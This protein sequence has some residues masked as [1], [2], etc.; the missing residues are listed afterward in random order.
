MAKYLVVAIAETW[1]PN[2]Y[3]IVAYDFEQCR[4]LHIPS[5]KL[6]D[7]KTNEIY[8]DLFGITHCSIRPWRYNMQVPATPPKFD[9]H[10][11]SKDVEMLFR[12]KH[13]PYKVFYERKYSWGFIKLSSIKNIEIQNENKKV[14]SYITLSE[15]GRDWRVLVKDFR[16]L[17]YWSSIRDEDRP[18]KLRY[19][20]RY[21]NDKTKQFY[22]T[23]CWHTFD[24]GQKYA[25]INGVHCFTS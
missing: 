20:I 9:K 5:D 6:V 3:T 21:L 2:A 7:N 24:S 23:T 22:A 10:W 19:W 16:W 14:K 18:E 17:H 11:T 1:D 13:I 4:N 8:W 15:N 25:W 12:T